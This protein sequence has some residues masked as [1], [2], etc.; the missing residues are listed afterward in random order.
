[1]IT[2]RRLFIGIPLAAIAAAIGI[3]GVL[4]WRSNRVVVEVGF[5]FDGVTFEMSPLDVQQLGGPVTDDEKAMIREVA[6][7][8]LRTAY[9]KLRVRL[10][11]NRR[12]YYRIRVVQGPLEDASKMSRGASGQTTV[13]GPMGG[14]STVSYLV[15]VRGAFAYAPAGATR[16]DILEG[17]GRGVGR[18]AVHELGHQ[19]LGSQSA[20]GND[21]RSYEYGSPDRIG[22]YYGPIHWDTAW[23][24]LE[25]RLG[26]PGRID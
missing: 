15:S 25:K 4:Q 17:I 26:L 22:Q 14:D 19:L 18:T 24:P 13:M 6:L 9:S 1:V 20:H 8:E 23:A 5:W 21:E 3:L 2:N 10:T 16:R 12:A 11:D 7:N